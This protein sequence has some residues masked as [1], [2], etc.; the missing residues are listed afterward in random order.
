[1]RKISIIISAFICS[2]ALVLSFGFLQITSSANTEKTVKAFT[3]QEGASVRVKNSSS[4]GFCCDIM[5]SDVS[6]Y[7]YILLLKNPDP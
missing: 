7:T 5:S 2:I 6:I 3:M 1:M 4:K